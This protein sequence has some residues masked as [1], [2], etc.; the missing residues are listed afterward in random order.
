MPPSRDGNAKQARD[1]A[2]QALIRNYQNGDAQAFNRLLDECQYWQYIFRGLCAKGVPSVYAED[3]TQKICCRLLRTLK[4]FRFDCTFEY[5]LNTII[6]N[7]AKNYYR[8]RHKKIN[9]QRLQLSSL[10]ELLA[11]TEEEKPSF[12]IPDI[13]SPSPDA[14]L[15]YE[16]LR[17]IIAACLSSFKNKTAKLVTCLLLK[18][19]KQRHIMTLLEIPFGT[20][21]GHWERGKK[22]L[23]YCIKKNYREG[24][25]LA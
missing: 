4:N 19:L 22:R 5:Y 24:P 23:R 10:E 8:M 9:G 1:E 12:D 21:G 14:D 25:A 18:G 3:S 2:A 20:V 17:R 16:D 13:N 7:E 6:T 15:S 11:P